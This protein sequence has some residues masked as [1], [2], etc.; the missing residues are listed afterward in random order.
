M[1]ILIIRKNRKLHVV[2]SSQV[3]EVT[4]EDGSVHQLAVI[5]KKSLQ[6][7]NQ[8]RGIKDGR[9]EENFNNKKCRENNSVSISICNAPVAAIAQQQPGP[10]HHQEPTVQQPSWQ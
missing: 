6:Y 2:I 1:M 4:F 8:K 9:E 5:K 3:K 7:L 10:R